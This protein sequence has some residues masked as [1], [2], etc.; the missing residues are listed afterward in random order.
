MR[1]LVR[2]ERKVEFA[3]EGLFFVDM[4]RWG[5][6]DLVN[7]QPSYGLPLPAIRYEGLSA[8]DIPNFKKTERHDLN[9]I[10]NY[11]AYKSKLRVRD[12]NRHWDK[13]FELWPIPSLERSRNPNLTQNEGY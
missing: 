7:G 1:Q 12:A 13:A 4:R 11:D 5:I 9:D 10:A 8:T 2:R 6:G 3:L